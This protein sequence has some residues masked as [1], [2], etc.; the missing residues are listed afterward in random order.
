MSARI[1]STQ[2]FEVGGIATSAVLRSSIFDPINCF[3]FRPGV[4]L[5]L[6]NGLYFSRRAPDTPYN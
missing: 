5:C 4:N 2:G 1:A 6:L 3:R